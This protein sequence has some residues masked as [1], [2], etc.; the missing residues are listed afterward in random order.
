MFIL[1]FHTSCY[2][3]M[4]YMINLISNCALFDL[5]VIQLLLNIIVNHKSYNRGAQVTGIH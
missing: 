4:A 2:G 1:N 3:N 5:A